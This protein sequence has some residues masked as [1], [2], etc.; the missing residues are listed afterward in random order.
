ML[1]IHRI[2]AHVRSKK[3]QILQTNRK[4]KNEIISMYDFYVCVFFPF[5]SF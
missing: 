2:D 5:V 3:E 1:L 4:I